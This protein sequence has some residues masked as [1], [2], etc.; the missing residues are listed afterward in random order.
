MTSWFPSMEHPM[1]PPQLRVSLSKS[2]TAK[3]V[4]SI[5]NGCWDVTED[6]NKL[7]PDFRFTNLDNFVEKVWGKASI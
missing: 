3:T 7:L 6:W 1:V 5:Y 4:L 2:F